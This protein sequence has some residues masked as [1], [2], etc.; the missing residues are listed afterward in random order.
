MTPTSFRFLRA[1]CLGLAAGLV[2]A[3]CNMGNTTPRLASDQ[4][5]NFPILNDFST[6]DPSLVSAETDWQITQNLFNGL[7]KYSN[8]LRIVPDIAS[9]LPVV[10]ADGMT[11]TF[12]LR[13]DVTFSNGDKVTST[14]VLYSWN[15][16]VAMQGGNASNLSA[17]AGYA[18]VSNNQAAG[19]ALETLLEKS[20]PSV[21]MF[22]LTA[23]D[24]YTVKVQ[25]SSPAG[26]FLP[27]LAVPGSTGMLVDQN[28]VKNDF[29]NWWVR[30]ATLIGT[31]AFK[32]TARTP[33]SA[34]F[35]AVPNWWGSPRPTLTKVHLDIVLDASAAIAAY[36]QGTYNLYGYGGYSSAP[37]DDI[38]RIQATTTEK[39][40]VLLH[41]KMQTTW[42]SFNLVSD[43]KRPAQGPFTM[44][45]GQTSHD[46]RLAFALA[47]DKTRL[48]A[49]ICHNI[50]CWPATGGLITKGLMG[51]LGDGNDPLSAFDA[52]HA[53]AFLTKADPDGS[54]TKGLSY[55]YDSSNQLNKD[56]ALFLQDQWLTNLG[57][58]VDV[59]PYDLTQYIPSRLKGAF[60][61]ARDDWQ[62]DYNHP[63]D[64]FDNRWGKLVGCPDANCTSGYDTV[65]YDTLLA[66]ADAESPSMGLADYVDLHH[67]LIDDVAYI[68]LYYSV[69]AFLIKPYVSGAGTNNFFDFRWNQIQILYH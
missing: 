8:D 21:T 40:Q 9:A 23:P 38:R 19:A 46:I 30:P 65:A 27:A 32:M 66:K 35:Q 59:K 64:W 34:D 54:K 4:T 53:K 41:P 6:L 39:A 12:A 15:R 68:P 5:L 51:Y 52:I 24:A 13:H 62:A 44:D 56:V 10:S 22:G 42:V 29:D 63:Q 26:W 16:A 17:I 2:L 31:G 11:Y 60:V 61:L 37:L 49:D 67:Q 20:D 25:L 47:I 57:V 3:A 36:E 45:G 18:A 1:L 14:D 33:Q 48:A 43:V 55:S 28:V 50:S 58:K 69:G 7:I